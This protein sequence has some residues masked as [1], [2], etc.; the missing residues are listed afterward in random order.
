LQNTKTKQTQNV[1]IWQN[2]AKIADFQTQST[3]R[4]SMLYDQ[5]CPLIQIVRAG[6]LFLNFRE[7]KE[8]K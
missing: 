4:S 2:P 7:K 6:F 3:A 1:N 5:K 8:A